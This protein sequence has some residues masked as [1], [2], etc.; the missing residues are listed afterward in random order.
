[1][2]GGKVSLPPISGGLNREDTWRPAIYA[3]QL[4]RRWLQGRRQ[5]ARPLWE[6][7]NH[8]ARPRARSR[9]GLGSGATSTA[10]DPLRL[11]P[12]LGW[13]PLLV[14]ATRRGRIRGMVPRRRGRAPLRALCE[15]QRS[16]DSRPQ[17]GTLVPRNAQPRLRGVRGGGGGRIFWRGR[18][19]GLAC[20]A[21][22]AAPAMK[23]ARA[24]SA[25]RPG[26]GHGPR[27]AACL[28]TGVPR[29]ATLVRVWGA[30]GDDPLARAGA[31]MHIPLHHLVV[32]I[33]P[34]GP[35]AASIGAT[36]SR[37][38][39][40]L[41]GLRVHP[42][43]RRARRPLQPAPGA[44]EAGNFRLGLG[45]LLL[46]RGHLA[47]Q[48]I[49]PLLLCSGRRYGRGVRAPAAGAWATAVPSL[50]GRASPPLRPEPRLQR[51]VQRQGRGERAPRRH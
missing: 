37:P 11:W 23:L 21:A 19:V 2:Q 7:L 41:I 18:A 43:G 31:R 46:N 9:S 16:A 45:Q 39:C 15:P 17:R 8:Y 51:A 12:L 42:R 4:L 29:G 30:P 50:Q 35:A 10:D 27:I 24:V 44:A 20:G 47:A 3:K 32:V 22:L 48:R 25:H 40:R 6:R 13:R 1:M 33:G 49:D 5:R 14:A 28:H 36:S 26:A 38:R 34:A